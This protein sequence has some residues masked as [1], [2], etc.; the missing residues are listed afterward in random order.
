MKSESEKSEVMGFWSFD[1][2]ETFICFRDVLNVK[3][4]MGKKVQ[5]IFLMGLKI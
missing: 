2:F 5:K 4:Y 1:F 3:R